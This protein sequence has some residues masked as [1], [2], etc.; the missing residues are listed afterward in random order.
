M[1]IAI[2]AIGLVVGGAAAA[3]GVVVRVAR[4][5][6]VGVVAISSVA[7]KS[8]A[9]VCVVRRALAGDR[10][11]FVGV[12]A[13]P[14]LADGF[15]GAFAVCADVA[16]L[17]VPESPSSAWAI[18]IPLANATPIPNVIAPAPSQRYGT[19]FRGTRRLPDIESPNPDPTDSRRCAVAIESMQELIS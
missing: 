9:G 8:F 12:V 1:E 19:A 16:L 15:L 4:A 18:P 6:V 3:G 11:T 17:D 14:V 2:G 10:A 5:G 7:A 13:E